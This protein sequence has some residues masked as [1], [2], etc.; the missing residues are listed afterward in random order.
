ML[1][2]SGKLLPGC[3]VSGLGVRSQRF[4]WG[5]GRGR[6]IPDSGRH[7]VTVDDPIG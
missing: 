3:A 7:K 6:G 2:T 5:M 1:A 4:P